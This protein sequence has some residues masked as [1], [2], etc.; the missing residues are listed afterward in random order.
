MGWSPVMPGDLCTLAEAGWQSSLT[1]HAACQSCSPGAWGTRAFPAVGAAALLIKQSQSWGPRLLPRAFP[2]PR[3]AAH[4]KVQP[5]ASG[6]ASLS[7][8]TCCR[9]SWRCHWGAELAS[10]GKS[11]S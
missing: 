4:S 2:S 6:H 5:W 9:K 8:S 10:V 7:D 11:N 3:P 1:A